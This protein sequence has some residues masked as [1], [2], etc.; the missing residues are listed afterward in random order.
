MLI[1]PSGQGHQ[2]RKK[3]T[4]F[5]SQNIGVSLGALTVDTPL[6]QAISLLNA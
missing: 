2:Y 5:F 3:I 4:P 6:Q 1:A